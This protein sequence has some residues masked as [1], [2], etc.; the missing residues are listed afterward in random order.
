MLPEYYEFLNSVKIISGKNAME[1][2]PFELSNLGATKPL[3]LTTKSMTKNGQLKIV[4]DSMEKS[5]I[6]IG[7]IFMDIPQDSS[8]EIVNEISKLY[9]EENCDSIIAMGGGSVIDTAKGVNM[10]VSTDATDLK[11]HMGLEIL[12]GK[13]NPL[14]VIPSTSGTGSEA[15]LVSVIADTSRNVKMEFISYSIL[16][17]VAV[18][19]PRMTLSLPVKLTASIGIDALTHSIEAITGFQ[20]NPLSRVYALTSIELISNYLKK[21]VENSKDEKARLAMANASLMAGIAFSNSMV[22]IVHAIGHACGAVSNVAHGDAMTILLSHCMELNLDLCEEEY[23]RIL[24]AFSGP[25][26]YSETPKA[27]RGKKCIDE[28]RQYILDLN[29]ISGLP[30]QLRDVGVRT[31]DFETIAKTAINDGAAITNP[32][33]VTFERVMEILKKAY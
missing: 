11:E 5:N 19:D 2:I 15:T 27:Q 3:I 33:E 9:R 7:P 31:E 17:D 22:G 32:V 29:K 26:I 24:L 25:E 16:P 18:L 12:G 1:N 30:I 10:L 8:V 20:K 13:L 21:A 6:E 28:I 4:T 14:I 23:S